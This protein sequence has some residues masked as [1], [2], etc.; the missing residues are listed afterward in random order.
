MIG[1][2]L[3]LDNCVSFDNTNVQAQED[4]DSLI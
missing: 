2:F 1:I 3:L 4:S